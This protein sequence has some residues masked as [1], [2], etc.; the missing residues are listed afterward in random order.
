MTD[1]SIDPAAV[2]EIVALYQERVDDAARQYQLGNFRTLRNLAHRAA[3]LA[4]SDN[5]ASIGITHV[6]LAIRHGEIIV[7]ETGVIG[8]ERRIRG[9]FRNALKEQGVEIDEEFPSEELT[10]V[11]R[12]NSSACGYAFLKC[13]VITRYPSHPQK[14][15]Y[16]I[17]EI[18]TA[19]TNGMSRNTWLNKTLEKEYVR[20]AA[21]DHFG[22]SADDLSPGM[23]IKNIVNRIRG[24]TDGQ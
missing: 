4:R 16:E 7:Q 12:K 14:K 5:A 24:G 8:H 1:M 21:I 11:T 18:E 13:A 10:E 9:I 23:M 19:L 15:Y 6:E 22:V 20:Q 3:L 17:A 2:N